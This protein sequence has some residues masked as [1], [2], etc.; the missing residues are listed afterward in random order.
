MKKRLRGFSLV[1]ILIVVMIIGILAAIALPKLSSASQVARE[2]ALK[3]N[4]RLLRTQLGVYK[5]QHSVFPGYPAGDTAQNPT[6]AATYD[7]LLQCTDGTGNTTPA[8]TPVYRWGPYLDMM[9]RNSVNGSSDVK[10][11]SD[12]DAFTPDGSTGWLYQPS[13]GTLKA[14]VAGTDTSGRPIIDY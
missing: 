3:D 6:A 1:E 13:T 7:Q 10:I 14:N 11:L 4:L 8:N 5:S 2:N 12:S 9:P